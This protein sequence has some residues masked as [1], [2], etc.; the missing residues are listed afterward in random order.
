MMVFYWVFLVF[1]LFLRP[2]L[3]SKA[4]H[5]F[6]TQRMLK[7]WA[8][9]ID[10]LG[11]E[12]VAAAAEIKEQKMRYHFGVI[13]STIG[14]WTAKFIMINCLIIAIVPSTPVDGATQAFLYARLVSMFV[15]MTFSPTPG[16]AGLAELALASFISD[17]VPT[18]IAMV[19]ALLWRGMAYYGY[20][21]LGAFIVP[22]WIG[23]KVAAAKAREALAHGTGAN[24]P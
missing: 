7:R 22:A 21:L 14:V 23:Q 2:Q 10:R 5:W 19:V 6:A 12:F 16:G 24:T 17:Y 18:G 15:I 3:A 4:L 11:R 8:P 9:K 20:L 13:G 1:F